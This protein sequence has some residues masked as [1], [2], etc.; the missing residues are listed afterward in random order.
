MNGKILGKQAL[1]GRALAALY[2][3]GGVAILP[4][5]AV[6][7]WSGLGP[8]E[9]LGLTAAVFTLAVA[10]WQTAESLSTQVLHAFA[11][12]GVGI[13]GVGL[14]FTGGGAATATYSSLY[15]LTGLF[16]FTF[17]STRA[18]LGHL[19]AAAATMTAALATVGNLASAAPQVFVITAVAGIV[20]TVQNRLTAELHREAGTDELTGLSNRRALDRDIVRVEDRARRL[21]TSASILALDVDNLKQVNDAEGHAAGDR[22]LHEAAAAWTRQV[23]PADTLAR[24]GGDEFIAVLVDC[25]LHEALSVAERLVE[26]TP[27]RASTCIGVAVWD[28]SERL[29]DTVDRSDSALYQAKSKGN[30]EIAVLLSEGGDTVPLDPVRIHDTTTHQPRSRTE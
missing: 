28:G 12:C 26:G 9:A 19:A 7:A 15:V 29:N 13:I 6:P 3:T 25:E 27:R 11:L 5:F 18:A 24:L 20:G 8:V 10:C 4:T 14:T 30:G 17:F 22:I 2:A 1:P 23:R 21:G 16:A